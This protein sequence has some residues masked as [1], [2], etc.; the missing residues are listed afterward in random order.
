MKI[1]RIFAAAAAMAV[2]T[3][4]AACE[5]KKDNTGTGEN[6]II[7]Y[8]KPTAAPTAAPTEVVVAADDGPR[9][10][11]KDTTV[12]AGEVAEVTIAVENAEA[13]WN[14]C[15]FHITYPDVLVPEMMD[16]EKHYVR[17]KMGEAS[18]YN[19]GSVAMEWYNNKTEHL[20][21]KKLGSIFFTEI[22]D[23]DYGLNGDVVTFFLKV[24]DDAESGT[25]YPVEFMYID[26]DVF[27]NKAEDKSMEK[28]VFENWTGGKIIVE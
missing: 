20:I 3:S 11:I 2:M 25:E 23:D 1:S 8:D 5:D 9:L 12:K 16:A 28:Y 13:A 4:M 6:S 7:M 14:M 15:G 19:V 24:P 17:K 26:G 21:T 10:S 27:S 22:F 18:E